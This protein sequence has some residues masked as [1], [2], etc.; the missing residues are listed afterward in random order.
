MIIITVYFAAK[1]HYFPKIAIVVAENH[2]N[3]VA[4]GDQV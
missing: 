4:P 2:V 3:G 1:L